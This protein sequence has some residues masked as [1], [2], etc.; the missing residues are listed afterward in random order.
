MIIR[1]DKLIQVHPDLAAVVK[2]AADAMPWDITVLEC[3][4]SPERQK[5]LV[6]HGASHTLRSRHLAGPDGLSRAV[7]LAPSPGGDITWSWPPYYVLAASMKTAAQQL[8][9]PIE[10]GGDWTSFKDGPHWQLPWADYP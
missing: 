9:I 7:D 2:R 4:R 8:G 3:L 5:E 10:W 6:A 1:E